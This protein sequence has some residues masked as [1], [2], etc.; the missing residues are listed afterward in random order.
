MNR[1]LYF[2]LGLNLIHHE[3]SSIN[4]STYGQ[5]FFTKPATARRGSYSD[6]DMDIDRSLADVYVVTILAINVLTPQKSSHPP[7]NTS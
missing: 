2:W 1:V 5:N 4:R 6:K 7:I 3:L